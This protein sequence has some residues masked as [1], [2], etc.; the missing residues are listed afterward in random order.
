MERVFVLR[1]FTFPEFAKR[2]AVEILFVEML[3]RFATRATLL[4]D[5][6]LLT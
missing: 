1:V 3:L 6:I 5:E 2:L 4:I